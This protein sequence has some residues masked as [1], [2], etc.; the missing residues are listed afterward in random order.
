MTKKA[1]TYYIIFGRPP[2]GGSF[3][4][5]ALVAPLSIG[6]YRQLAR[7]VL[8]AF[9]RRGLITVNVFQ[10]GVGLGDSVAEK[11]LSRES[12]TFL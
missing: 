5:S 8:R 4:P 12:S 3:P 10:R 7:S 9:Y 2:V 6:L 11:H 1:H